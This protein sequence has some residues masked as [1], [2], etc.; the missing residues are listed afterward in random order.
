MNFAALNIIVL[1]LAG[2]VLSG[3][4]AVAAGTAGAVTA[5]EITDDT[6][7]VDPLQNTELGQ[8]VYD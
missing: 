8:E 3:C 7:Q 4:A 6:P 1:L 2:M 5:T